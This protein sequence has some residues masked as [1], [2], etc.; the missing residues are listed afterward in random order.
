MHVLF[1]LR[2]KDVS[3]L[4]NYITKYKLLLIMQ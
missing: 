4:N 2:K 1:I 3:E